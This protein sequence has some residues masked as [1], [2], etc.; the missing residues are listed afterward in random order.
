MMRHFLICVG[1]LALHTDGLFAQVVAPGATPAAKPATPTQTPSQPATPT[2]GQPASPLPSKLAVADLEKMLGAIALYPDNLLANVLAGAVYPEEVKKAHLFLASG[3]KADTL[4]AQGVEPPIQALGK[5][6][7]VLKMMHDNMEWTEALGQAYLLQSQDVMTAV[8][9]LRAKAKANGVLQTGDQQTVVQQGETIIIESSQPDIIYVPSYDP[10]VVYVDHYD[11]GDAVA[12]GVIGF[13]LGV[14]VGA[15]WHNN[16]CDW[17]HGYVGW[18]GGYADVDI[19]IDRGDIN[20]DN[21]KINNINKN[22]IKNNNVG[23]NRPGQEGQQWKPNP[24]KANTNSLAKPGGA[25]SMEKFRGASTGQLPSNV[26]LPNPKRDTPAAA[27][28]PGS[29]SPAARAPSAGN[30]AV[31]P[32]TP[33]RPSAPASPSRP[34]APPAPRNVPAA[35]SAASRPA[36]RPTPQAPSAARSP[37]QRSSGGFSTSRSSASQSSRGSMSR[38]SAGGSR[39]GGRR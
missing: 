22:D 13:G 5:V 26:K 35:P 15:I 21:S 4:A 8:Q 36:S 1:C 32:S 24:A 11:S 33:S 16:Y 30:T 17:H 23:R 20:I 14:A 38:G 2:S 6:P 7:E 27:T 37:S 19:D 25:A 31:R 9:N 10:Q 18:G 28:R 3:G 39:G 34:V 12:A 29:A